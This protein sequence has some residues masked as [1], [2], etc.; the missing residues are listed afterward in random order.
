MITQEQ[1]STRKNQINSM[2]NLR[3]IIIFVDED[4]PMARLLYEALSQ[5]IEPD[6]VQQL[7]GSIPIE[8][9]EQ[10]SR[11]KPQSESQEPKWVEPLTDR[12]LEVLRLVAEGL[13]RREI[14]ARLVLS[15]NTVKAHVRNIYS[16]LD[17]NNQMKAVAKARALGFLENE[18]GVFH[19]LTPIKI[20]PPGHPL[21]V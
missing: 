14:A 18:F 21:G 15:L 8:K 17:V 19:S 10:M 2:K 5:E 12:E 1:L 9:P 6:Y 3:P 20:N 13:S 4:S 16:K 11:T 7:F